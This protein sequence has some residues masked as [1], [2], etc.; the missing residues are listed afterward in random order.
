MRGV[1]EGAFAKAL[2]RF[3]ISSEPFL[4]S[5]ERRALQLF[6]LVLG[7]QLTFASGLFAAEVVTL[8]AVGLKNKRV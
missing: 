2:K 8:S 3:C 6:W 1:L 7:T 4:L 5:G